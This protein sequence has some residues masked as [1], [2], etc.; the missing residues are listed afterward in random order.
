MAAGCS[1]L[2]PLAFQELDFVMRSW[3]GTHPGASLSLSVFEICDSSLQTVKEI[4]HSVRLMRQS[5]LQFLK[6]STFER[7]FSF[8]FSFK[9]DI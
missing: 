8:L 5:E 7:L 4:P 1:L 6:T 3:G 2:P 9:K